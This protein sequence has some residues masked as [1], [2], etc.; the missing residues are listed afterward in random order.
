[1]ELLLGVVL[2][3]SSVASLFC[4]VF[5]GCAVVAVCVGDVVMFPDVL[6]FLFFVPEFPGIVLLLVFCIMRGGRCVCVVW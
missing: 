3:C 2:L 6:S 4:C 1:M 5:G